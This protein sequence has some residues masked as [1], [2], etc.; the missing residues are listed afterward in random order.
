MHAWEFVYKTA[1][2]W[3]KLTKRPPRRFAM[4][5]GRIFRAATEVC[6]IGKRGSPIIRVHDRL[7]ISLSKRLAH[8]SKPGKLQDDLQAMVRGPRLELFARRKRKGWRC[9]GL[10]CNGEDVRKSIRRLTKL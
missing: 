1:W 2:V 7:N 5:T 9:V 4:G 3:G 8:S 10:E 6:L